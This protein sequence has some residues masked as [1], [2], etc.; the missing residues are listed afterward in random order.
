MIALNRLK[1]FEIDFWTRG[2]HC[3]FMLTL[4]MALMLLDPGGTKLAQTLQASMGI[5]ICVTLF[6][7]I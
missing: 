5:S 1:G 3:L 2:V 7:D 6:C 4:V